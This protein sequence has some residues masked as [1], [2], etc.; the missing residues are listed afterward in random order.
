MQHTGT[1]SLRI[2]VLGSTHSSAF[3]SFPTWFGA[4]QGQAGQIPTLSLSSMAQFL[5]PKS[6]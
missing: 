6:Y 5:H 4:T 1:K 2:G 3:A